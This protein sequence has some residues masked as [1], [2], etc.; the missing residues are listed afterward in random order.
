MFGLVDQIVSGLD[1]K[2]TVLSLF[3]DL[4]K[5]FDMIIHTLLTEKLEEVGIRGNAG[6]WSSSFLTNRKQVVEMSYV[7][8]SQCLKK[9][10]SDEIILK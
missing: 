2:S 8:G 5:A 1:K 9:A 10:F 7:D 6:S 4:V 3:M